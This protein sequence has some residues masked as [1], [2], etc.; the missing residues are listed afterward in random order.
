[1]MN[2]KMAGGKFLFLTSSLPPQLSAHAAAPV[3]S[4]IGPLTGT[5][6]PLRTGH[7]SSGDMLY[8]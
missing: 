2:K 7:E 6:P 1:M 4:L 8:C 5:L 3:L